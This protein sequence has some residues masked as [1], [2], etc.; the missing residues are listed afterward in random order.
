MK[1]M[2]ERYF[3][4]ICILT[5]I[6]VVCCARAESP[7]KVVGV[8]LNEAGIAFRELNVADGGAYVDLSNTSVS[9]LR[10]LA[11]L[12]ISRL[13]LT[14]CRNV[15]N[16][17]PL[18]QIPLKFLNITGTA[19]TDLGPLQGMPLRDFGFSPATATNNVAAVRKSV[20]CININQEDP[21]LFWRK[22]DS[23]PASRLRQAGVAYH[24]VYVRTN[25][26]W[27]LSLWQQ[28]VHD[29]SPLKGLPLAG[30]TLSETSVED[31]SPLRGMPLNDLDLSN[32]RIRDLSPLK[33]MPL[34]SLR[35]QNCSNVASIAALARVPLR[36]L[37]LAGTSVNDISVLRGMPLESLWLERTEVTDISAL[38]GMPLAQ[39]GIAPRRV[40][41]AL[42]IVAAM[43]KYGIVWIDHEFWGR[44]M[45]P[46]NFC[47]KVNHGDF[48]R[49]TIK[50][51]NALAPIGSRTTDVALK[52]AMPT[53]ACA[54]SANGRY[55]LLRS[56][57]RKTSEYA[58]CYTRYALVD[59]AAKTN[60]WEREVWHNGQTLVEEDGWTWIV[61]ADDHI[62]GIAPNGREYGQ[63]RISWMSVFPERHIRN[64]S[65]GCYWA[66]LY[67]HSF[68]F[69]YNDRPYYCIAPWWQQYILV[70]LYAG[71]HV[72]ATGGIL[73][74][75]ERELKEFACRVL[76]DAIAKRRVFAASKYDSDELNPVLTAV[77]FAG[78]RQIHEA[79]PFLKQLEEVE[80]VDN[81]GFH[82]QGMNYKFAAGDINPFTSQTM[83]FRA[84]VQLALRRLGVVP[85][86]LPVFRFARE[87]GS[88]AEYWY[89]PPR[90]SAPRSTRV[91]LI[92]PGMSVTDVLKM[93]GSP[94]FIEDYPRLYWD[95]DIDAVEPYT[96]RVFWPL[97]PEEQEGKLVVTDT[98]LIKPPVW[99]ISDMREMSIVY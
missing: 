10:A 32:T 45:T 65:N 3:A 84:L 37:N 60:L 53:N 20:T 89:T 97:A 40:T 58:G 68:F 6:S 30:L 81:E 24:S 79:I 1:R 94:D 63:A 11:G 49:P 42:A 5:A 9:D 83:K 7:D 17:T 18:A 87:G 74:S 19:V 80:F 98:T 8:R 78:N 46:S 27:Y 21:E 35:L 72:P 48:T 13:N 64:T 93:I 29:L 92:R 57:S 26:L 70:D 67:S 43:P 44:E 76:R 23:P 16:L 56:E 73:E 96:F 38:K 12:P 66:W 36:D 2:T 41:N 88:G 52:R 71:K 51:L 50:P 55:V 59:F 91:E 54:N 22:Y 39:L 69:R 82:V 25:G 95:Y 31:L 77:I 62:A 61:S 47:D 75:V 90:L 86:C 4:A 34:Q 99:Q 33:G 14:N 28:G 85:A 15:T